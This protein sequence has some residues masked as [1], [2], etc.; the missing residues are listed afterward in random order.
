[1]NYD[2]AEHLKREYGWAMTGLTSDN[3]LIELPSPEGRAPREAPRST[4]NEILEARAEELLGHIY[5][6]IRRVGLEQ[7][8]L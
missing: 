3:S 5:E 8:L 7:S 6:E 2:D 1:M 4:I